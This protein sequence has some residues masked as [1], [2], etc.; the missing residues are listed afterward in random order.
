MA[1][2][3]TF[4]RFD[5][6]SEQAVSA[7]H[8]HRWWVLVALS[9][10]LLVVG[11][12]ATVLNVALADISRALGASTTAL[13]WIVNGYALASAALLIP[14][15]V[16]GDRL[17]R[18]RVLACGLALFL[19]ASAA[20]AF[21]TATGP[22]IVARTVMGI[23]AAAVFPLSLS[24][25]PT[26][27]GAD[28]RPR[29]VATVTAAM[30][31]GM[32]LGPI[33]G[34]WLLDHFWWGSTMLVNLPTVGIALVAVARLVPRSRDE[35]HAHLDLAGMALVVT[36][37]AVLIFGIIQGPVDGWDSPRVLGALA[38][39]ALLL[40]AFAVVEGRAA[41]PVVDRMLL[42]TRLF[43][44]PTAATALV[45]FV[46][47]GLMFTV[48]LYLQVVQGRTAFQT[49]LALMPT[50]V[51]LVAGAGVAAVALPRL[52][53]RILVVVGVLVAGLGFLPL[54]SL[55]P[56]DGYLRLFLALSAIGF[57]FGL[58]MSPATDAV[59]GSLPE[60]RESTGTAL[61]LSVKQ[62]GGVFGVAVLGALLTAAYRAGVT[63]ATTHLPP[64]IA[65]AAQGSVA[66]AHAAAAQLPTAVGT[67][68][69]SSA[70][71]AFVAGLHR[72]A[73]VCCVTALVV[74]AL[75]AVTLPRRVAQTP[76][77][78]TAPDRTAPDRTRTRSDRTSWDRTAIEPPAHP[79]V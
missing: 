70:D 27:F 65:E 79:I 61:N 34:G 36:G 45:S 2:V 8:P 26:V 77:D 25:I 21:S 32:P 48:P 40:A 23:G 14:A 67:A 37:L 66:G 74:A 31:I 56:H 6:H 58:S 17:G 49:G 15:G 69:R 72:I 24:I 29:A 73:L 22:L 35:S 75:M 54:A 43:I 12:D 13:Q 52:G 57:G 42:R 78:R 16:L 9:L 60:G 33:L 5:H 53:L 59:L 71:L 7:S 63:T 46:M 1:Q 44:W 28:E 47:L 41:E 19:I 39:G 11:L 4:Q 30:G 55:G 51:C 64:S 50:M 18:R 76:P 62:L 68:L 38:S 20:A 10:S 3:G